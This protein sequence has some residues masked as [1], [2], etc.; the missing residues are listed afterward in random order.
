MIREEQ[1]FEIQKII[2][3]KRWES[4]DRMLKGEMIDYT[5]MAKDTATAILDS[6]EI[7]GLEIIKMFTEKDL[8]GNFYTIAQNIERIYREKPIKIKGE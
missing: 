2:E 8:N 1:V 5:K 4:T 7:D 3:R 6:I